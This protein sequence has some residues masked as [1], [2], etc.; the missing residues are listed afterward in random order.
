[1]TETTEQ[2]RQRFADD[3]FLILPNLI[4][5]A[6]IEQIL[7]IWRADPQLAS[8]IKENENF[9]GDEGL[10]TRLAY[11]PHLTDDAYGALARSARLVAPME[12]V[13]SASMQHYY[14]LNMQKDPGT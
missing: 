8:E 7:R 13:F 2:Y 12:Q 11:R 4:D 10:R 3:G 9:D 6:Q 5:Q 1:M 14:T